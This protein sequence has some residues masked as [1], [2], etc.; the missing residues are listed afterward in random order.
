ME[1]IIGVGVFF[2]L[3]GGVA[4]YFAHRQVKALGKSHQVRQ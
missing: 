4:S 3:F 1:L 2:V